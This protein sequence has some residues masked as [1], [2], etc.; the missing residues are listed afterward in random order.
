MA[1][2]TFSLA[3]LPRRDQLPPVCARCGRPASGTRRVRLKT[4]KPS[5]GPDLV[6]SLAGVSTDD[7]RRWHDFRQLFEKG[8]GVFELPACWWHR[9]IV[10]P[11]MGI[12]SLS[13]RRVTLWGLSDVF[14]RELKRRGWMEI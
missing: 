11:L 2:A 3:N 6:A 10:P 1:E 5:R 14:I 7:Q 9:W 8:Y 12:K 13:D 4:H